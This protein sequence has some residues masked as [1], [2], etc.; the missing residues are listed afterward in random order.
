M[1]LIIHPL[2]LKIHVLYY[3]QHY[4]D[5]FAFNKNILKYCITVLAEIW[6]IKAV[7]NASPLTLTFLCTIICKLLL[8]LVNKKGLF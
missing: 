5:D 4:Q 6:Y 3:N 2:L 1:G 8:H 7:K